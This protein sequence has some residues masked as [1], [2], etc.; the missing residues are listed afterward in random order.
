MDH[1]PPYS[2]KSRPWLFI[3]ANFPVSFWQPVRWAKGDC[4]GLLLDMGVSAGADQNGGNGTL[5]G[6]ER[7][8][9][10]GRRGNGDVQHQRSQRWQGK[11]R[12]VAERRLA[13]SRLRLLDMYFPY[14]C[15]VR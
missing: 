14:S 7:G 2:N 12:S 9:K 4:S 13:G 15:G 5:R 6:R 3:S 11:M 10:L 8:S 1:L